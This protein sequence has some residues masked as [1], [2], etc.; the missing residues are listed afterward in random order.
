[1][2]NNAPETSNNDSLIVT[3]RNR[4]NVETLSNASTTSLLELSS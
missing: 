4:Y 1:M 2:F 3:K